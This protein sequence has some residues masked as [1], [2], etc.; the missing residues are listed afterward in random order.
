MSEDIEES[1]KALKTAIEIE[2]T[3]Y[4]TF[5]SFADK[6]NNEQGKKIFNQL[7][8][9]EESH[10][11]I[12][13]EQLAKLEGG[14]AWAEVDIPK[15]EIEELAPKIRERTLETKGENAVGELD[16][17]TTALD[18]EKRAKEFFVERAE[19][20]EIPEAKA[21]FLRLAEWEETH[22]DLIKA[23]IDNINHTGFYFDMWEFKMDGQY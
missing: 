2:I 16:A 20:T 14:S 8:K 13:E 15:S 22:Y 4:D 23:E 10:R 1:I 12:L 3:G 6:T 7:A 17:L 18:L 11:E 19:A 5:R 21:L 9:D